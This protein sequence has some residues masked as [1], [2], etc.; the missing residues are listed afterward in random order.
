MDFCIVADVRQ[1]VQRSIV[2]AILVWLAVER[3][4]AC[5]QLGLHRASYPGYPFSQSFPVPT[6]E[7]MT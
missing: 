6:E 1:E 5:T 2:V 3:I 4:E 7:G